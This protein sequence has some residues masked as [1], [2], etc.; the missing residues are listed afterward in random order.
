MGADRVN[1]ERREGRFEDTQ[2]I[3]ITGKELD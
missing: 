3:L 1:D 2:L